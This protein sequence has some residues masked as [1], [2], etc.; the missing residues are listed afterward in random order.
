MK[1]FQ[2]RKVYFYTGPDFSLAKSGE[3]HSLKNWAHLLHIPYSTFYSWLFRKAPAHN[4]GRLSQG[5]FNQCVYRKAPNNDTT[6]VWVEIDPLYL[7][8]H[9]ELVRQVTIEL[10]KGNSVFHITELLKISAAKVRSIQQALKNPALI[11][12]EEQIHKCKCPTCGIVYYRIGYFTG[13]GLWRKKHNKGDCPVLDQVQCDPRYH[14]SIDL[15][16]VFPDYI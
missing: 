13:T 5:K 8:K 6:A 4:I 2:P 3:A 11:D 1:K 10:E 16:T 12:P 9:A 15:K 14:L 7:A